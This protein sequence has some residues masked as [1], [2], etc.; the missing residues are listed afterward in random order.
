LSF[1]TEEEGVARHSK[2]EQT[3]PKPRP[4]WLSPAS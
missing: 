3:L 4:T 1:D 2:A